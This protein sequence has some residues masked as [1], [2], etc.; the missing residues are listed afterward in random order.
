[1]VI[2][3]MRNPCNSVEFG[4][5]ESLKLIEQVFKIFPNDS[6]EHEFSSFENSE[7]EDESIGGICNR[8]KQ[9]DTIFKN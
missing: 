1:M 4:L 5:K 6:P 3:D 9:K 7:E 2:H 8:I